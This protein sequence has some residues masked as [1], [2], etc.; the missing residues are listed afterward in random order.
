MKCRLEFKSSILISLS[1]FFCP[2]FFGSVRAQEREP[3]TPNECVALALRRSPLA[4]AARYAR[5]A[6]QVTVDRDKP[7]ARPT[8]TASASATLQGPHVTFPRVTPGGIYDATVLPEQYGHVGL[9]IEQPLYRAGFGAARQR[10]AAQSASTI[11]D[12][13]RALADIAL[14]AR[15]ACINLL[16]AE[17]GVRLAED[18]LAAAVQYQKLVT[19]QIEAGLAKPVDAE[20]VK[21]S[22]AEAQAALDQARGGVRLARMALNRALG[23]PLTQPTEVVA[24]KSPT[25]VPESPDPAVESALKNRAELRGLGLNIKAAQA[26]VSL[27]RTQTQPTLGLRGQVLEQTPSAF[28]NEHYAAAT[29]ELKWNLFDGGKA[30]LDTAE[31][32]AQVKRLEALLED[33]RS[34]IM[35]DVMQNW[36]K[37]R[38]IQGKIE[39]AKIQRA[40]AEALL[41]VASTAYDI[42]RGTLIEML[43]AAREVRSA[44]ERELQASYD[45]A[46]GAADFEYAQGTLVTDTDVV[47]IYKMD[48]FK[49]GSLSRSAL[50]RTERREI[51]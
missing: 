51:K 5:Q 4:Q 34:G 39:T 6:Q 20:T 28:Q 26:G 25:V 30:R 40:G 1:L 12:Y 46:A 50:K 43:A 18:G 44:K 45:L 47:D 15:K 27:A 19:K 33:V 21:G 9:T 22:V 49:N 41:V 2:A 16:R 37:L 17:S 38:D 13:R 48:D 24:P 10:Y 23:L 8:V 3:L 31:A 7:V 42:G 35:L 14:A 36:Q 11:Q 32:S 29:V